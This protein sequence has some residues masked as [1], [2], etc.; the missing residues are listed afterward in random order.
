MP[1]AISVLIVEDDEGISALMRGVFED[2]GFRV[3]SALSGEQGLELLADEAPDVI[4][5]D[6]MLPGM[7]GM[8]F[9][10]H[11]R[12]DGHQTPV[13]ITSA[14]RGGKQLAD[15]AGAA[16]VAKPFDLEQLIRA[17]RSATT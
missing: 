3:R 12:S 14:L 16:F 5:L 8:T 13:V 17:V 10:E 6:L 7:S 11:I 15:G 2:E 4:V 1:G 9:L